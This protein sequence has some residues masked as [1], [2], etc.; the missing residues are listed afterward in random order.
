MIKTEIKKGQIWKNKNNEK[1]L[2]IDT[3]N[4]WYDQNY[5]KV[6][7]LQDNEYN[8]AGHIL[9]NV[10]KE[11]FNNMELVEE[12]IL[13]EKAVKIRKL[14]AEI[15]L[16]KNQISFLQDKIHYNEQIIEEFK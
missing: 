16:W 14:Q 6:Q 15:T 9:D 13:D 2:V 4:D 11:Q 10:D 12:T 7:V 5:C 1:F 8:Y 3:E